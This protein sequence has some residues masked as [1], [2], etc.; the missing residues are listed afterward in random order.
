MEN[1]V[2]SQNNRTFFE[3]FF[4]GKIRPFQRTSTHYSLFHGKTF[5]KAL[6]H[7]KNYGK[8][9]CTMQNRYRQKDRAA[10][11]PFHFPKALLLPSQC[12]LPTILFDFLQ[13]TLRCNEKLFMLPTKKDWRIAVGRTA[14]T[15]KD[16][17]AF[18]R[19]HKN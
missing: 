5:R 1:S 13:P 6:Y 2:S 17:R 14:V 18:V 3:P 10:L 9:S 11:F 7:N 19:I 12:K 8:G 4:S 15:A 16:R